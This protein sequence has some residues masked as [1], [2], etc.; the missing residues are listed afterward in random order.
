MGIDHVLHKPF[1]RKEYQHDQY[2]Y[3]RIVFLLG[4]CVIYPLKAMSRG[5]LKLLVIAWQLL[6]VP[7]QE[8][9]TSSV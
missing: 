5:V 2:I 4:F 7:S 9:R 8:F 1:Y 6:K 3:Q